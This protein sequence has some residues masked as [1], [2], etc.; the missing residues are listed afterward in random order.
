MPAN[1]T[2]EY[3]EAERKYREAKSPPEKIAAL[4][5]MMAVVPKHKGTEK[6]RK[7]LKT[8][9]SKLRQAQQ[10]KAATARRGSVPTVK[11]EGAGQVFL[12]GPP[13]SGKSS[14]LAGLTHAT[15]DIGEYP[16]TT[17]TLIPGM[18]PY[19]DIQIQLVDT[20]PIS[21]DHTETW[22]SSPLRN[23]DGILVVLDL[24]S[25]QILEEYEET[26]GYLARSKIRM[27]RSAGEKGETG[28]VVIPSIMVLNKMDLD[29]DGV[30]EQLLSEI[31]ESSEVPTRRVCTRET[32]GLED[33][34]SG[35][36]RMLDVIRVY[37]KSPGKPADLANPTV[38]GSGCTALEFTDKIHKDF[39]DKF[40]F[41]RLWRKASSDR[42]SG[43]DVPPGGIRISRDYELK[44]GD[45]IEIHA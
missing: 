8:K 22:L 44:D 17:R 18:M 30:R 41:A 9:L 34:R 19:E 26:M 35:I 16:F 3:L 45:V 21:P 38:V 5:E 7:E 39:K 2:P 31:S 25:D 28:W 43:E 4:E 37:S 33:L 32:D 24:G 20:P 6:L 13:N 15:P 40:K 14:L 1:L 10:K 29:R 42:E 36:F 23:A 11:S 12:I 27:S